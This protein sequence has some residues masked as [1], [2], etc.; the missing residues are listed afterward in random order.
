M[1]AGREKNSAK[2][3][4]NGMVLNGMSH[5]PWGRNKV[6]QVKSTYSKIHQ[7]AHPL[8]YTDCLWV[9]DSLL[10]PL[11]CCCCFHVCSN[12][13][14][15][16]ANSWITHKSNDMITPTDCNR[17]GSLEN[18]EHNARAAPSFPG[19]ISMTETM[20]VKA[21]ASG[22]TQCKWKREQRVKNNNGE[23]QHMPRCQRRGWGEYT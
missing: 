5:W 2:I 23:I 12:L 7:V 21:S 16:A 3:F 18:N 14:N 8:W 20:Q 15:S 13:L 9:A 4:Q 22:E 11:T 1:V 17:W 6:V 10:I 19:L